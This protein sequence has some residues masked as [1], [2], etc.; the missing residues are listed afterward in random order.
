M[1]Q[2][3]PEA[4][5]VSG[6]EDSTPSPI[7]GYFQC[8]GY[9][10]DVADDNIGVVDDDDDDDD[11]VGGDDDDM[12]ECDGDDDDKDDDDDNCSGHSNLSAPLGSPAPANPPQRSQ[13]SD[14]KSYSLK[15]ISIFL[16]NPHKIFVLIRHF[17]HQRA[18][19]VSRKRLKQKRHFYSQGACY[20]SRKCL[21]RKNIPVLRENSQSPEIF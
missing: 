10:D 14:L 15:L 3:V 9:H 19:S 2:L 17:C 7:S 13:I 11:N 12:G 6:S 8:D 21:E 20:V 1:F 16:I 18:F 4:S 5:V